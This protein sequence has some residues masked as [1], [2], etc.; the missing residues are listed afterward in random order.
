[1]SVILITGCSK[2][3]GKEA[4]LA[5]ARNGDT[6][7]ATM[8]NITQSTDLE[9]LAKDESLDLTILPLDVTKHETFSKL[10]EQII[11]KTGQIDV[12]IN[13]AGMIK[14]GALEDLSDKNIREVMETN[15]FGPVLLTRAV[16][17]TMRKQKSG[18]I[19]M[20]SSLS[21][22]VARAGD[23]LYAA[24]KSSLES[25]CEAL[26]YEVERW[27][28]KISVVEPAFFESEL[29]TK[30]LSTSSGNIESCLEDSP[31]SELNRWQLE[32][33]QQTVGSGESPKDVANL[34]IEMTRSDTQQ[35]RWPV[36]KVADVVAKVGAS[37][38]EERDAFI[39]KASGIDWWTEGKEVP[40][41]S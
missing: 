29:F 6:V 38:D 19:I 17:P 36:G 33:M 25:V 21:A 18:H 3:L 7:I 34:L 28:I 39:R 8:R 13:N 9:K 26:R 20:I 4:A 5:F 2:G 37:N 14:M 16:L 11:N 27:G 22:F 31:Y 23:T 32:K 35:L 10:V 30:D 12:L 24:S 40:Q 41:S 15:F 1:M